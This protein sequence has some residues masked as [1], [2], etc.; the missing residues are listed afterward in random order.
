MQNPLNSE[1]AKALGILIPRVAMGYLMTMAGFIKLHDFGLTKFVDSSIGLVPEWF[2]HEMGRAYLY[3]LPFVEA[4]VGLLLIV[5]LLTRWAA[6]VNVLLLGSIIYAM[7]DVKEFAPIS[8]QGAL[9]FNVIYLSIAIFFW[10][11]GGGKISVDQKIF[12]KG[13]G[14]GAGK[15]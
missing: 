15:K 13:G 8:S 12:G 5:G 2:G 7:K 10:L 9:H 3:T 11:N 1:A 6:F 4:A 14:G